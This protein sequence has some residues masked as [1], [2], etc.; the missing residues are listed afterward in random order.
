MPI[1]KQRANS[2][3]NYHID[4]NE[5]LLNDKDRQYYT[6]LVAHWGRNLLSTMALLVISV[7]LVPVYISDVQ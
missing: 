2:S 4:S 3:L 1:P 5:I 6:L 7:S